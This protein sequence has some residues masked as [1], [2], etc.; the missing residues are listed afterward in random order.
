M[1]L[2][3]HTESRERRQRTDE[4]YGW[5]RYLQGVVIWGV[6][7]ERKTAGKRTIFPPS[8]SQRALLVSPNPLHLLL[9]THA[10]T[11]SLY[12][13]ANVLHC[14]IWTVLMKT[15]VKTHKRT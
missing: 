12:A 10:L 7:G 13:T 6:F 3:P 4:V 15:H 2:L 5:C 11:N 8:L 1:I 14:A 9:N